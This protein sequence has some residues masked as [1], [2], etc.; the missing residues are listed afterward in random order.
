MSR[1]SSRSCSN[2]GSRRDGLRALVD[3]AVADMV[4]RPL[5]LRVGERQLRV[6]LNG[7]R[8]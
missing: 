8:W 2:S 6:S 3:E 4:Q 7:R 5:E 1:A